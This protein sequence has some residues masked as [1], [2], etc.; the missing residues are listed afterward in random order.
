MGIEVEEHV[1]N[2]V[3]QASN[4]EVPADFGT[5]WVLVAG[6]PGCATSMGD[7]CICDFTHGEAAIPPD[8][9]PAKPCKHWFVVHR[10]HLPALQTLVGTND[11]EVLQN[12]VTRSALEALLDEVN[13]NCGEP[14]LPH[15]VCA[16]CGHYDG[17]AVIKSKTA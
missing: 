4:D 16:A 13:P 17:R 8:L 14:K 12:P 11:L 1:G 9:A 3:T 2:S 7:L 10:K 6:V 15:H 5:E